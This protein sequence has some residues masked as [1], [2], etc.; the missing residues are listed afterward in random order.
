MPLSPARRKFLDRN[1]DARARPSIIRD[2]EHL[3]LL[4]LLPVGVVDTSRGARLQIDVRAFQDR[5]VGVV[6]RVIEFD[7]PRLPAAGANCDVRGLDVGL[8]VK[9]SILAVQRRAVASTVDAV[10][11][12]PDRDAGIGSSESKNWSAES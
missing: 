5:S 9:V 10:A 7:Q 11:A 12:A 6:V 3:G 4:A 2:G 8:T 1:H